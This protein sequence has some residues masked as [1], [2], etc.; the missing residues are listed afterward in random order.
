MKVKVNFL[1][2]YDGWITEDDSYKTG[3]VVELDETQVKYLLDA[4]VVEEVKPKAKPK[5]KPAPKK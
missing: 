2:D 1:K 5:P 4:E 3:D